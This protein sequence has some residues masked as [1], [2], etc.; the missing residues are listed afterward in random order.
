MTCTAHIGRKQ[1]RG[2][3]KE[4]TSGT[5]VAASDWIAKTS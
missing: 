3:G 1:A 5:K 2:L 4:T